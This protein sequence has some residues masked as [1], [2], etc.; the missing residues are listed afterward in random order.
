LIG[1]VTGDGKAD[2]VT[3]GDN[4]VAVLRSHGN[5]FTYETALSTGFWGG[6]G[7]FLADM[8]GDGRAD[9]VAISPSAITVRRATGASPGNPLFLGYDEIW[10]SGSFY[11][12]QKTLVRD[13][14]G[15][16]RAD[17]I[18]LDDNQVRVLRAYPGG[19]FRDP[20]VWYTQ[21]YYGSHAS[22]LGDVD[23]N[24]KADVI[25]TDDGLIAAVRSQ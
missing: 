16:G 2:L 23:G 17:V 8:D 6:V 25:V 12:S 9:L 20:E 24:G 11:G 7:T 4:Y 5:S 18:A 21:G 22:L 19:G 15:D 3:L 13:V 10:H 14:D 1:D